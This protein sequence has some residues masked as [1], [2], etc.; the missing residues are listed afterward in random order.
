MPSLSTVES[1]LRFQ[2]QDT[3][4]ASYF[5]ECSESTVVNPI[6][7][8]GIFYNCKAIYPPELSAKARKRIELNK[9]NGC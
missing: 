5:P 1:F 3:H 9:T 4:N 2:V 7:K 8:L 6:T